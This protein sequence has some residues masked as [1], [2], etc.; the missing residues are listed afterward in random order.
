MEEKESLE[1]RIL[2][3]RIRKVLVMEKKLMD[4]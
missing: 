3:E 2:V 4:C 1:A